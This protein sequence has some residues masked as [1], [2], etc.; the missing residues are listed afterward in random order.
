MKVKASKFVFLRDCLNWISDETGV[1]RLCE[2]YNMDESQW[3]HCAS[4]RTERKHPA[5][6]VLDGMLYC[7]G[8][9][10][11][12]GGDLSSVEIYDPTEDHWKEGVP[13]RLCK[14]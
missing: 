8:G 10:D 11:E 3:K 5:I 12:H 9:T 7:L 6:V 13:M 4:L 2:V 1:S 14:G